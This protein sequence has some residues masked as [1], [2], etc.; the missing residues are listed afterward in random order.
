MQRDGAVGPIC[1]HTRSYR[2]VVDATGLPVGLDSLQTGKKIC[3]SRRLAWWYWCCSRKDL[4]R[5]RQGAHV[6][7]RC[8]RGPA[9]PACHVPVRPVLNAVLQMLPLLLN[10]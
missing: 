4:G 1:T 8:Y 5:S 6:R 7:L 9:P 10:A 3:R 2:V